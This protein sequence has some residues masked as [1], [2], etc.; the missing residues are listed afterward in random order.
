MYPYVYYV[1]TPPP[2]ITSLTKNLVIYYHSILPRQ[3]DPKPATRA[4]EKLQLIKKKILQN[5]LG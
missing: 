4:G 3:W 1:L 2:Q 5:K